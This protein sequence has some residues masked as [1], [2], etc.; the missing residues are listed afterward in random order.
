MKYAFFFV[1]SFVLTGFLFGNYVHAQSAPA[2]SPAVAKE[3][4]NIKAACIPARWETPDC[5]KTMGESNLVLAS[6]YAESLKKDGK[7]KEADQI[8]QHC[9]ASTAAR[10]QEVPAY[11][12]KSAMTECANTIG[13]IAQATEITPDLTHYQLFFAGVLCLSQSPECTMVEDGIRQFQ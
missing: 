11:A 6:S 7:T 4:K 5:L 13:D 10:E 8:V 2:P 3:I 1:L 12:M 9:A